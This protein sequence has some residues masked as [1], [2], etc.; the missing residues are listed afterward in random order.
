[1]LKNIQKCVLLLITVD[2]NWRISLDELEKF[3]GH[4]IARGFIGGRT[5]PI[6]SM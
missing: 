6:L 2:P 5:L 1:M 4:I 3:L